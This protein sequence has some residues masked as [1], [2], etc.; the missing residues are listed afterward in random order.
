MIQ[1]AIAD[2]LKAKAAASLAAADAKVKAAAASLAAADAKMKAA[3]SAALSQFEFKFISLTPPHVQISNGTK[4][5]WSGL[6]TE[7]GIARSQRGITLNANVYWCMQ[8]KN[9]GGSDQQARIGVTSNSY[10]ANASDQIKWNNM[11][12]FKTATSANTDL[13]Y[14]PLGGGGGKGIWGRERGEG[15]EGGAAA[16]AASAKRECY[17]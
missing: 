10:I 11:W 14:S 7:H 6:A 1:A 4:A 3:A 9:T 5:T 8:Y 16:A 2:N 17:A 13:V 12:F 15:E